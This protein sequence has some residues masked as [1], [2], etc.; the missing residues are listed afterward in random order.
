[1][2]IY[3]QS[4]AG[5]KVG[6]TDHTGRGAEIVVGVVG[7]DAALDGMPIYLDVVLINFQRKSLRNMKLL[8][9]EVDARDLLRNRVFDLNTCVHFQKIKSL[10]LDIDQKLN[11]TGIAISDMTGKAQRGLMQPG[12]QGVW[13]AG[14]RGFFDQFLVATLYGTVSVA[15]MNDPVAV[16]EY[17]HFYVPPTGDKPVDVDPPVAESRLCFG[18]G[19][20]KQS[21]KLLGAV[22][23]FKAT[24]A[25]TANR[26]DK[27]RKADGLGHGQCFFKRFDRTACCHRHTGFLGNASRLQLVAHAANLF[28]GGADENNVVVFAGLCKFS[29]FRKKPV[30]GM[31]RLRT[32]AAGSFDQGSDLQITFVGTGWSDTDA[33]VCQL[34]A[35]ALAVGSRHGQYRLNALLTQT[36]YY[37]Y[38]DFSP[39]GN[40]HALDVHGQTPMSA[41]AS[42]VG[43]IPPVLRLAPESRRLSR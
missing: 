4:F 16:S 27:Y 33:A 36:A 19:K 10:S 34:S 5:G 22:G 9:D 40:E 7:I 21:G 41:P 20:F 43:R 15:Q 42:A 13:Q 3:P 1:M 31:N 2:C 23:F 17:L 35:Q 18:T 6:R 8:R 25:A 24:A 11:R 37:S 32:R 30:A 28:G 12:P 38:R 29:P 14:C 39:V 26:L